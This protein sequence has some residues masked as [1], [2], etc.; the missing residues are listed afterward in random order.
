[1]KI[2]TLKSFMNEAARKYGIKD[3][4]IKLNKHGMVIEMASNNHLQFAHRFSEAVKSKLVTE[5]FAF[6]E[7]K[8]DSDFDKIIK[9]YLFR[10][11]NLTTNRD[12]EEII[13]P[14]DESGYGFEDGE[15]YFDTDYQNSIDNMSDEEYQNYVLF[16]D[17]N[18]LPYSDVEF[19]PDEDNSSITFCATCCDVPDECYGDDCY[20]GNLFDRISTDNDT[21]IDYNMSIDDMIDKDYDEEDDYETDLSKTER[22]A[23]RIVDFGTDDTDLDEEEIDEKR[24]DIL[25]GKMEESF[26]YMPSERKRVV[27]ERIES[28]FG[29]K[30]R[31]RKFSK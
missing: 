3:A 13:I 16:H 27:K 11:A 8:D 25:L 12:N 28:R 29:K 14:T 21:D 30:L 1:M 15:E 22:S 9:R 4:N 26:K 23:K 17:V 31:N 19:L 5:G 24:K 20:G 7:I 18:T 6:K 2:S 10:N